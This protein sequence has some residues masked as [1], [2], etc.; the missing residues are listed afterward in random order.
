[1]SELRHLIVAFCVGA[2]FGSIA[3]I[4]SDRRDRAK[5]RT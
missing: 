1:M 5:E 3:E 2:L 4:L